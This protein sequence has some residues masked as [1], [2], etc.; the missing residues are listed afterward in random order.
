MAKPL[1][2]EPGGWLYE[3]IKATRGNQ[4]P[5]GCIVLSA[6]NRVPPHPPYF[7]PVCRIDEDGY[8]F[9]DFVDRMGNL[10]EAVN[11]GSSVAIGTAFKRIVEKLK[12]DDDDVK[13]LGQL[14]QSWIELDARAVSEEEIRA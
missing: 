5:C 1:K 13:E 12:L 14:I 8:V 4:T 9:T 6:I 3:V 10:H 7:G 11:I 2:H